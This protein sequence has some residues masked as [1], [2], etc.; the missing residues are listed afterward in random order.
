[1]RLFDSKIFDPKIFESLFN[2]NGIFDPKI[3]DPKIF[4]TGVKIT[5]I[6]RNPDGAGGRAINRPGKLF[7]EVSLTIPPFVMTLSMD[8]V[9]AEGRINEDEELLTILMN[10]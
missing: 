5:V 1:M 7:V 2:I 4:D 9:F 3:F 8:K 10:I 6:R